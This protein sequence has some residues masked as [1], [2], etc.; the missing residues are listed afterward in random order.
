MRI[1]ELTLLRCWT[2]WQVEP[3]EK[4]GKPTK[5]PYRSTRSRAQSSNPATWLTLEEAEIVFAGLPKPLPGG[6]LGLWLGDSLGGAG[7]SLGGLD[8]DSC[9]GAEGLM[10]WAQ[11]VLDLMPTY[12]EVSP[13]GGGVKLFFAYRTADLEA[14][15]SALGL[16]AEGTGRKWSGGGSKDH[17]PGIEAYLTKRYFALTRDRL[18]GPKG[19]EAVD[20]AALA[21]AIE[22]GKALLPG[23]R[24]APIDG[25]AT[26]RVAS[27]FAASGSTATGIAVTDAIARSDRL[28]R[29]WRGDYSDLPAGDR[30]RSTVAFNMAAVMKGYGIAEADIHAAF[31]AHP[32]IGG[33]IAEKAQ[34][35]T[36]EWDRAMDRSGAIVPPEAGLGGLPSVAGLSSADAAPETTVP[37]EAQLPMVAGLSSTDPKPPG[38]SGGFGPAAQDDAEGLE[39]RLDAVVDEF[40][41]QYMVVNE[42][43]KTVVYVPRH[44]QV[45]DRRFHDRMSFTDLRNLYLNRLVPVPGKGGKVEWQ[46][47]A[48]AWLR[49]KRRH[50][51]PKGVV[52]DPSGKHAKEGALN[53]WQG[54]A[55]EAKR[56]SWRR[57]REH[58]LTVL[59]RGDED[60]L[61]YLLDWIAR[62]LQQPARQGEVAVVMRGGEG[63]G[64]GTLAR[65]LL[66][67]VGQH[68]V[69]ISSSRHLTGNFNAHLRDCVFL[70]A[71]EAFFAGDKSHVGVL[72]SIITEPHLTIESKYQNAITSPNYLHLMMASNEEWVVPASVGARRFFVLEVDDSRIGDAAW[73][74]E[75]WEEM[76]NGGY[77][78][79]LWDMT[80]RDL[81][82]FN[83]RKVPETMGLQR[84]KELTLDVDMQWWASVL[85]RGYLMQNVI[86]RVWHEVAEKGEVLNSYEEFIKHRMVRHPLNFI[87]MGRFMARLKF[88]TARMTIPKGCAGANTGVPG[89]G[90]DANGAS[91]ERPWGYRLGTLSEARRAFGTLTKMRI[92]WEPV[93][94]FTE[95]GVTYD[96]NIVPFSQR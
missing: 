12:R 54:F 16:G 77:E 74:N 41:A 9:I 63:T 27:G 38:A 85:H 55:V 8:L 73:F 25:A 40:N 87:T 67:I 75:L 10:P 92:E 49:H 21:S 44:D 51:Y 13:S 88:D 62:M 17:P 37:E 82:G 34:I 80:R 78:A 69:P 23:Y 26:S 1:G 50:Q 46:S 91:R 93:D 22:A 96:G 19:I 33:W 61:C 64:K 29:L 7:M 31:A 47:A 24:E 48:E 81:S 95:Q 60:H 45:L 43:G 4:T 79:L 89:V 90:S 28:A 52:F 30:S 71:D 20:A 32:V 42:A 65:V 83:V 57:L 36:R 5:M 6:G 94:E 2:A 68:G 18:D 35:G 58:M 66:R 86:P 70:F 39:N 59:C 11:A 15:R 53:L 14:F 84:Q 56:G 72:K 76:E 3:H